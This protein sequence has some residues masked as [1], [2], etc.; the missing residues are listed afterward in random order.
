VGGVPW[1]RRARSCSLAL[2]DLVTSPTDCRL[3]FPIAVQ[4][5]LRTCFYS[6]LRGQEEASRTLPCLS[7]NFPGKKR[8]LTAFPRCSWRGKGGGGGGCRC[9]CPRAGPCK[10]EIQNGR[11][12]PR[13]MHLPPIG[14]GKG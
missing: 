3:Y 13:R 9:P 6:V 1:L 5:A 7:W 4:S 8:C 10:W 11:V 2:E 12:H 14:K